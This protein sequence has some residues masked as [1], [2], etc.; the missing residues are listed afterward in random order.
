MLQSVNLL[1]VVH[2]LLVPKTL[3]EPLAKIILKILLYP[4]QPILLRINVNMP[5]VERII[6]NGAQTLVLLLPVQVL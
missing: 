6:V 1:A 5:K 2:G 3:Q 4:A